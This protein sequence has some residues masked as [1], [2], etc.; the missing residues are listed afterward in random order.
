M[1]LVAKYH[2]IFSKLDQ[3]DGGAFGGAVIGVQIWRE[4]TALWSSNFSGVGGR[5]V[6]YEV[7]PVGQEVQYSLTDGAGHHGVIGSVGEL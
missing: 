4:S 5:Q 6:G 7:L 1:Y 2:G 3:L